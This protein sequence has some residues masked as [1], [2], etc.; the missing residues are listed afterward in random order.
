MGYYARRAERTADP[1]R[2][3]QEDIEVQVED[4]LQPEEIRTLTDAEREATE[5]EAA[6]TDQDLDLLDLE[7][8]LRSVDELTFDELQR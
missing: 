7:A 8:Q 2:P 5:L 3:H 1:A 4:R 6:R